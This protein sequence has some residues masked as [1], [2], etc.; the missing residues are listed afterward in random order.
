MSTAPI[1]IE[2]YLTQVGATD[3]TCEIREESAEALFSAGGEPRH[4]KVSHPTE[5]EQF[6]LEWVKRDSPFWG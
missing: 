3:I 6:L 2:E 1:S 4:Y 5:A